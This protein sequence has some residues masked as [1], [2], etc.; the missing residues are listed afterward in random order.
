MQPIQRGRGISIDAA[1]RAGEAAIAAR[2]E[3][4][5][6]MH[7]TRVAVAPLQ[8]LEVCGAREVREIAAV[9]VVRHRKLAVRRQA[10]FDRP[11]PE[12]GGPPR[13]V[14]P[15]RATDLTF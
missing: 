6:D 9:E 14:R 11:L 12:D 1:E 4:T 7:E 15:S 13:V 2:G 5:P 10:A 8:P 3:T